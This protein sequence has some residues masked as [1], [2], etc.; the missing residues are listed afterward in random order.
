[1]E[2]QNSFFTL[3]E[4]LIVIAIIAILAGML[5]PA[6][7]KARA[8]AKN[9]N[10][11]S[12]QRQ[13]Y[14]TVQLYS[15]D[16]KI[17]RI[18]SGRVDTALYPTAYGQVFPFALVQ[19]GYIKENIPINSNTSFGY[20][21]DKMPKFMVCPS[22]IFEKKT[23]GYWYG[24]QYGINPYVTQQSTSTFYTKHSERLSSPEKTMYFMDKKSGNYEIAPALA[25]V[26]PNRHS[27]NYNA[28]FLT[29][30]VRILSYAKH[31]MMLN[32][33]PGNYYFFRAGSVLKENPF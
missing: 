15:D 6:L 3:I 2:K 11:V 5:L 19:G 1:M 16:Y 26:L 17:E 7:N 21:Y 33:D 12:N 24:T 31:I 25:S 22:E 10:C 14:L 20:Y 27:P 9:I 8:Q 4:L 32:S 23:W 18:P 28:T 30:N 29:G 13:L